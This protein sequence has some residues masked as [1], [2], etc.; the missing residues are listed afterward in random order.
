MDF[1]AILRG[2]VWH[3]TTPERYR[4]I[5]QEGFLLPEPALPDTERWGTAA[6]PSL[7]PYVRSIG[8][9]SLFDFREFDETQ[10]SSRYPLSMWRQFVPCSHRADTA[11]WIEIDLALVKAQF[12]DGVT[13][14]QRWKSSGQ[15]GRNIMPLIEVAHV[16]PVPSRAFNR[17][18]VYRKSTNVFLEQ[19]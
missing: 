11:I 7:Y 15:L 2:F 1:P 13:L 9:V 12:I 17:V 16:G 4:S 3:T 18:F 14:L 6:G 5:C 10:Y 19:A 8:G